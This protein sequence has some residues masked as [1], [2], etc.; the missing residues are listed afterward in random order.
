[1]G[2][3]NNNK[4]CFHFLAVAEVLS[5]TRP[6]RLGLAL[7]EDATEL[8]VLMEEELGLRFSPEGVATVLRTVVFA[9]AGVVDGNPMRVT[10]WTGA[11]NPYLGWH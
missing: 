4:Q 9:L 10:L 7:T 1:M 8:M 5:L 11:N 3:D 2:V 6:V